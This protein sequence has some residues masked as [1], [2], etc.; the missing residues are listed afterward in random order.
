LG[1]PLGIQNP[2]IFYED[3]IPALMYGSLGM[4]L[5][6]EITHGFDTMG[7]R[8]DSDGNYKNWWNNLTSEEFQKKTQ[9]F[10]DQY[11]KYDFKV[12][13]LLKDYKGPKA[14]NG[15][16]TLNE[17]IADNGGMREAWGA[18]KLEQKEKEEKRLPGL[19]NY[20]SDQLFF[21]SFGNMWCETKSL[22]ALASQ[23]QSDPHSPAPVRVKAVL[24]NMKEFQ[25]AFQCKN[26][27]KMVNEN[28]C[29]VW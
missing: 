23:L 7:K 16:T 27:D 21:M 25:D 3:S 11:N 22:G 17:N 6:H 24:S 8:F 28:K 18:Y 12:F 29:I 9:C 5:G 4:V 2:P 15:T 10:V 26:G 13:D 19:E 1:F 14:T 20:S